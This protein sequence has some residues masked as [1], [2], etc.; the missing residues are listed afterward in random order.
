MANFCTLIAKHDTALLDELVNKN[1]YSKI[2][3][4]LIY[5]VMISNSEKLKK[6][7]HDYSL[8]NQVLSSFVGKVEK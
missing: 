3:L 7:V 8:Y 5:S 4:I 6:K 2:D 1:I